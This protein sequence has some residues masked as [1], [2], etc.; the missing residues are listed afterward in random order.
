MSG[1]R[2]AT[3]AVPESAAID[4]LVASHGSE[5]AVIVRNRIQTP[6]LHRRT[7]FSDYFNTPHF[8]HLLHE[9][10]AVFCCRFQTPPTHSPLSSSLPYT[11]WSR[12]VDAFRVP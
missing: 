5:L 12:Y 3:I 1:I 8:S 6:E 10:V 4:A 9:L 7:N 2:H 11:T